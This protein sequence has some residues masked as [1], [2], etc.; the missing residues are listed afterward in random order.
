MADTASY[1][2]A[3]KTSYPTAKPKGKPIPPRVRKAAAARAR[4]PKY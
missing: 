2:G 4:K 3:M 1:A